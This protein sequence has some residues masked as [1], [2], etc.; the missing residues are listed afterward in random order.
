[1]T[2]KRRFY[3]TIYRETRFERDLFWC[4]LKST[5]EGRTGYPEDKVINITE[6]WYIYH[7][8]WLDKKWT[9]NTPQLAKVWNWEFS[10]AREPEKD[11]HTKTSKLEFLLITGKSVEQAVTSLIDGLKINL[12]GET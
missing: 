2:E 7:K 9:P 1:M 5:P 6:N 11:N 3:Y 4:Q 8:G 10:Q 12:Y